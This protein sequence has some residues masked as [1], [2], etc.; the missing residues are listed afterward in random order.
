M[1]QSSW[2]ID[3]RQFIRTD[4]DVTVRIEKLSDLKPYGWVDDSASNPGDNPSEDDAPE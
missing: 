3:G 1:V 4:K 2:T